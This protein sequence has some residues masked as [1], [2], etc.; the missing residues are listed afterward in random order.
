MSAIVASVLIGAAAKVGAPIVKGLLE[1]YVGGAA[2]DIGGMVIDTIAAQAGVAPEALPS[3]PAKDLEAAV[4]AAEAQAPQLVA[5]W[6]EQQREANRL[7]LAEMEKGGDSWW[8]WAWRP[9]GMWIFIAL[10]AWYAAGLPIINL[11]LGL[12]GTGE[13]L[14][15]IVDV[16]TMVTMFMFFAG[17]YMGGHTVKDFA[18]KASEAVAAWGAK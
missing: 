6:V 17:F 11:L 12:L 10:F 16:S 9:A 18:T 8:T 1:K 5:A 3:L 13:R 4:A 2:S 15:L 7:M 14:G